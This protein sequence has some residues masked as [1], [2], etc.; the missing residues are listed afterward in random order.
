V[1]VVEEGG[2][3]G[4]YMADPADVVESNSPRS[5]HRGDVGI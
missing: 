2:D 4:E 5:G 1:E 3:M